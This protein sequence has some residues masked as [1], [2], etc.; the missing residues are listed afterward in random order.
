MGV[1]EK[2]SSNSE[3]ESENRPKDAAP[4]PTV[5][6]L[7]FAVLDTLAAVR[8][9]LSARQVRIGLLESGQ[10]QNG[11]KFYQLMRRLVDAQLL[12]SW[13]Q[14]FDVAGA[15]VNR[16]FYKI[17]ATGKAAWRLTLEFYAVR[18]RIRKDVFKSD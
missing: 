15:D 1:I 18:L 7:Q 13:Q 16:T 9:G 12:E 6:H 3:R 2:P 11:P 10:E 5:T 14:E 17:T 4:L 8:G